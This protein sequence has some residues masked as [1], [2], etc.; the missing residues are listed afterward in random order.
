[1][2]LP[3]KGDWQFN[4]ALSEMQKVFSVDWI[5]SFNIN[6]FMGVTGSASRWC[7]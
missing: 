5:P 4:T 1:M 2:A 3:G 7:C 6:Y